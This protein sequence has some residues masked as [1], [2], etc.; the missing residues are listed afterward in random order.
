MSSVAGAIEPCGC[1]E[2]MLGG[3]DH[4]AAYIKGQRASAP[5]ALVLG[6]G[7][8]LYMNARPDPAKDQ[9]ARFKAEALA[10]AFKTMGLKAWA[11][12][13]NDWLL[14]A[15]NLEQLEAR[16]GA[17]LLGHN[18]AT[19]LT[20]GTELVELSGIKLGVAGVSVPLVGGAAPAAVEVKDPV[21]S[22]E[23]A[24]KEL[25]QAGT[26]IQILLAAMPRG[27]ALRLV[28]KV[29]GYEIAVLGK[30]YD[31]GEANDPPMSPVLVGKTLVVETPNHLQALGVIDLH[32]RGDSFDF[33]DGSG[34]EA[35]ERKLEIGRRLREIQTR[36]EQGGRTEDLTALRRDQAALAGELS[37]LPLGKPPESGS[38]FRYQ[39]VEVKEQL[40]V[41]P[42]VVE[43]IAAYY[44]RVNDHN[45]EAYKDLLPPEPAPGEAHY[46]G[47]ERCS[48][49][50]ESQRA[51]WNNTLH[52][53]AYAALS[54]QD[55]HFNLECVGCHVTGY[56]RP[57]G[58]TVTHVESLTNVQCEVC[59]GPGSK[60]VE[61]PKDKALLQKPGPGFCA[62]ECHHPPHVHPGWSATAAWSKI[63][64]PGHGMPL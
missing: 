4:A 45:R 43:H 9:Q 62:T 38:Y 57:G 22:A 29:T 36:L 28:E 56:G 16:S 41:E 30:P 55:K 47:V 63:V 20:Q 61:K 17:K 10:D 51:F 21:K 39:N 7:P 40:G 12:G 58:S 19:P 48:T 54:S 3:A 27:D 26:K 2:D 1:V 24:L 44:R 15:E 60:H 32:V 34:L 37:Q 50:H 64:G 18:L 5:E 35:T 31:Q 14:G 11:P 46:V 25:E 33:A 59:H 13:A 42:N 8:M 53:K 6:A 52:S 23:L 49:C